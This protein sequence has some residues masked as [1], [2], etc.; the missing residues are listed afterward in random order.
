MD[1]RELVI[2]KLCIAYSRKEEVASDSF[3][4]RP[5]SFRQSIEAIPHLA[6]T[7]CEEVCVPFTTH[8]SRELIHFFTAYTYLATQS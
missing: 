7:R 5:W 2:F 1:R 4:N 6:G 8:S 3:L